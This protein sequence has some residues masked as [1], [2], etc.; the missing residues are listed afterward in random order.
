MLAVQLPEWITQRL[1]AEG[2]WYIKR[3]SGNDTQATGSRQAGPYVPRNVAFRVFPELHRPEKP[4]PRQNFRAVAGSHPHEASPNIIWYN[5][6][7]RNET[8]LTGF[9]GAASPL[10][11]AENT[12]S[13]ALF[14]FAENTGHRECYYWVCRNGQEED[15]AEAFAGP[16]EPGHPLFWHSK[17]D[18]EADVAI[19]ATKSPCWLD[20]TK[21]PSKWLETFPSPQEVFDTALKFRS[22]RHLA[23]DKRVLSRRECEY[24]VFRSV[25][26]TVE[27]AT[28]EQGFSTIDSFLSKA[29]TI[30]QR[31]KS[32]SGRSLELQL[33]AIF[34]EEGIPCA[35][36]PTTESGRRPDFIFPSQAAYDNF[37]YPADRLRMLAAKTTVKERWRQAIDEADRIPIKHIFTLQEGVSE[38][39]FA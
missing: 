4:N 5:R 26:H 15:I 13:V 16:V 33:R 25:E 39:Q 18:Q 27:T 19:D 21:I 22:Y 28:I 23:P 38:R 24:A 10:L 14:F 3:L 29:Q 37:N 35:F 2:Y 9:G 7:T 8:R 32:R 34:N 17:G 12:G 30:L 20:A 36:Q 6:G 11:D 1:V 31:R